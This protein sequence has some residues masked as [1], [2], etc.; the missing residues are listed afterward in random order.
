M[1][2]NLI[3]S[4]D[5]WII[6]LVLFVLMFIFIY[7]G[8]VFGEK[9][10]GKV[11]KTDSVLTAGIYTLMGLLLAFVFTM[12]GSRFDSRKRDI[13]EESNCI[14]TAVLRADMYPDSIRTLFKNEFREYLEARISYFEA[15]AD[16]EKILSSLKSSDE[17]S[18]KLWLRATELS[19]DPKFFVASNQMIPALNQ[20]FDIA[21]TR[22]HGELYKVPDPIVLMLLILLLIAG[23]IFG[24]T[25]ALNKEKLDWNLAICFNLLAVVLIYF[26]LDLDRPR[27][28]IINL[29]ETNKAITN[30][31]I[32]FK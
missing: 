13:V 5:A 24:Y 32:M 19:Q 22:L 4:T 27:R 7:A 6:S 25:S 1:T 31:R 3:T 8:K 10:R 9:V 28:G 23:F 18:T 15:H 29:D 12:A 26:I 14:S 20:M 17:Y 16:A 11:L 2:A 21:N 30:L